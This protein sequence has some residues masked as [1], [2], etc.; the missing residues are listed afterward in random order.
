MLLT[1]LTIWQLQLYEPSHSITCPSQLI[2]HA[3]WQSEVYTVKSILPWWRS[4]NLTC[5]YLGF[6][7]NT[8]ILSGWSWQ[9]FPYPLLQ[10]DL[11]QQQLMVVT[12]GGLYYLDEDLRIWPALTWS[13]QWIHSSWVNDLDSSSCS[14]H[15]WGYISFILCSCTG[16][17]LCLTLSYMPCLLHLRP[18]LLLHP[19]H[20]GIL[21]PLLP[22]VM[23]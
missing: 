16:S 19:Y 4:Q 5:T 17:L 18:L 7:L 23:K 9:S 2:W 3:H 22:P 20:A 1:V 11:V 10:S 12:C 21:I 6:P 13:S 15:R 8:L 14:P